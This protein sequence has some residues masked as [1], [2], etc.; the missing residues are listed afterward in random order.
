MVPELSGTRSFLSSC[1]VYP[2]PMS[3]MACPNSFQ[4]LKPIYTAHHH[5]SLKLTDVTRE[6]QSLMVGIQVPW[7][8][9]RE[10]GKGAELPFST[11]KRAQE[12]ELWVM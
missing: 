2:P 5:S 11:Q 8:L 9:S 4:N 3:H 6:R 12:G 7:I 10:G 1:L